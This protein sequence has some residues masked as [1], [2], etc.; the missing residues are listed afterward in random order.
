M[1]AA[2][3]SK[4]PEG[5]PWG[6]PGAS[7]ALCTASWAA[8]EAIR[9]RVG[10]A[11][12]GRGVAS[13][14]PLAAASRRLPQQESPG[15]AAHASPWDTVAAGLQA[16]EGAAAAPPQKQAELEVPGWGNRSHELRHVRERPLPANL[17]SDLP[18]AG[19]CKHCSGSLPPTAALPCPVPPSLAHCCDFPCF[20]PAG[21]PSMVS[22]DRQHPHGTYPEGSLTPMQARYAAAPA[23]CL[24]AAGSGRQAGRLRSLMP[25][26]PRCAA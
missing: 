8:G 16:P 23:A 4:P 3:S 20:P 12:T 7:A 15:L 14:R 24:L 5:P 17:E 2:A 22:R 26:H 11:A 25:P 9:S 10:S 6:L 19:G 1:E 18:G 21:Q 13:L